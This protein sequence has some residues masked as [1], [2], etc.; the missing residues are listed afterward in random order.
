MNKNDNPILIDFPLEGEWWAPHSPGTK[1]PSHGT[2]MLGQRYA[3][4]FVMV[5]WEKKKKMFNGSSLKYILFGIPLSDWYGWGKNI[6]APCD[7]KIIVARGGLKERKRLNII[8]DLLVVI[9]NGLFFRPGKHDL[10]KVVGNYV[11]MQTENAYACFAHFQTDSICVSE[12]QDVKTGELLGRVGHSGNS[13]AP[14]LHFQMMDNLDPLIANGILCA[15]KR[16]ERFND[17][18][19]EEVHNSIPT[20]EDRIRSISY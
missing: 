6:Y 19:W 15:F 9:K 17:G 18:V 12:G 11:I 2:D 20:S 13:T 10:H 4:D 7:G 8:T 16:Y 1:V 5:D 14:H 3:Y